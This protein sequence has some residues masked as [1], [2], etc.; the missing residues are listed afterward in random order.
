M[1]GVLYKLPGI[2]KCPTELLSGPNKVAVIMR[3][4]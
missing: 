4:T 2:R 3:C 1:E